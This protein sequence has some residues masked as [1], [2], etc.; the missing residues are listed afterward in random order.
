MP[1]IVLVDGLLETHDD[2]AVALRLNGR[3]Q[4]LL[5]GGR[6]GF[7]RTDIADAGKVHGHGG[8]A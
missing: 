2:G 5:A 3:Q 7:L 1:Q 6:R 8:V 4:R